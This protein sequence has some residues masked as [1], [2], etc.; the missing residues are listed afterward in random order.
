MTSSNILPASLSQSWKQIKASI[1]LPD[2][3][4]LW[5]VMIR[6]PVLNA[7]SAATVDTVT[8]NTS[9]AIPARI[10]Y[11]G[12][13]IFYRVTCQ[14]YHYHTGINCHTSE[15]FL[16]LQSHLLEQKN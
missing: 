8:G 5:P 14:S 15:F 2:S 12:A 4:V 16:N 3:L 13:C 7:D 11:F 10:G 6:P 1:V 9:R